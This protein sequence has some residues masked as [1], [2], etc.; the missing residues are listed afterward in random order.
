[1]K[2]TIN[3]PTRKE[4]PM[5]LQVSLTLELDASSTLS[6][7]EEQIQQAGHRWMAETFKQAVRMFEKE[8][9]V[10]PHCESSHVRLEGT[11]SRTVL[12]QFGKVSLARQ[13]MRCQDCFQRFQPSAPL[14]QELH[15]GRVTPG[16]AE[17]AVLAGICL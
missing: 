3:R 5:R 8:H 14:W 17:A 2:K 16:L 1:M 4:P 13:R 7:L 6:D 10:C 15:L 11:V 9:H 12:T